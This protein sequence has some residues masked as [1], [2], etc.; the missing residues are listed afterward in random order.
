M[1]NMPENQSQNDIIESGN[2]NNVEGAESNDIRSVINAYNPGSNGQ[3]QAVRNSMGPSTTAYAGNISQDGL[4]KFIIYTEIP[5]DKLQEVLNDQ[6]QISKCD[7]FALLY[8]NDR[9]HLEF[10]R[11]N[12]KK[13][14]KLVPKILIQ[15]KMDLVQNSTELLMSF[16][17]DFAK[18]LGDIKIYKQIS[19]VAAKYQDALDSI[20][21]V[22]LDPSKGLSDEN[23]EIAKKDDESSIFD[24]WFA[25]GT[26][27]VIVL[28]TLAIAS[29]FGYKYIK[30]KHKIV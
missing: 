14:P 27:S 1:D 17:D 15:T 13:L 20:M 21:Q 7:C 22:C 3:N 2:K 30:H 10:L 18:E 11:Q 24:G 16:Q 28:G 29:A 26:I 23:L 6:E 8:E 19:V 25:N 4:L 9:D 12:V 5:D